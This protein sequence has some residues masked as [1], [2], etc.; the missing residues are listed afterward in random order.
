MALT[1]VLEEEA[2]VFDFQLRQTDDHT[3]VLQLPLSGEEATLAATRC[4]EALKAFAMTQGLK[5]LRMLTGTG[6][7]VS[8][9][10]SGKARR[11]MDTRKA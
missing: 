9:G 4:C 8:R 7:P 3:L 11:V 10:R 1:T 2:G 5:T 6:L